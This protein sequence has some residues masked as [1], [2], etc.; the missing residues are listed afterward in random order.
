MITTYNP[1]TTRKLRRYEL[2]E[3]YYVAAGDSVDGNT[4]FIDGEHFTI[5]P[6]YEKYDG[7]DCIVHTD[8]NEVWAVIG[9]TET[10]CN[11]WFKEYTKWTGWAIPAYDLASYP[12]PY[13]K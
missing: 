11:E 2:V 10:W 1:G 8:T 6:D 7:Q 9:D 4:L 3:L 13:Q 12:A 5:K